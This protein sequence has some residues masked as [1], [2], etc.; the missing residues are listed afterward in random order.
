MISQKKTEPRTYC[1]SE[2]DNCC[3]PVRDDES[4]V[5]V[6]GG[7]CKNCH[8]L[9][10]NT[11]EALQSLG[12]DEPVELVTDMAAIASYGV[13][14]TPALVVDGRVVSSGRVLSPDQ[15][16]EAIRFVREK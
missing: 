8:K 5:K 12:M 2:G 7:G 1:C 16:K 10:D 11:Q 6:L 4:A 3:P 9:M 14:S 15:A 13:M